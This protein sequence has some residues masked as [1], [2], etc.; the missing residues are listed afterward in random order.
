MTAALPAGFGSL[1]GR[2]VDVHVHGQPDQAEALVDRGDDVEG[3]R[4]AVAYGIEGW[5]DFAAA[6]VT[7]LLDGND[8]LTPADLRRLVSTNPERFLDRGRD[9]PATPERS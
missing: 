3:A 6:G 9:H 8:R 4:P 2:A 7:S 1:L 5:A